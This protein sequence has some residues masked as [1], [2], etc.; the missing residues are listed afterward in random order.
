MYKQKSH[1]ILISLIALLLSVFTVLPDKSKAA[2]NSIPAILPEAFAYKKLTDQTMATNTEAIVI[3]D[4]PV[5]ASPQFASS[6]YTPN[7]AGLYLFSTS[8]QCSGTGTT[9][10]GCLVRLYKNGQLVVGVSS[11]AF[12]FV[13]TTNSNSTISYV[14]Y[15][16]GTTDY[17]DVRAFNVGGNRIR[18]TTA[19]NFSGS[20]ILSS[21][22]NMTINNPTLDLFLGI[23]LFYLVGFFI[24]WIFKKN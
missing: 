4:D 16:N 17:V 10:T 20:F 6:T 3:W 1:I 15:M 2:T 11:P 12:N 13:G 21:S 9:N 14:L 5:V 22:T 7:V 19:S 23:V 18:G 24:I 8:V